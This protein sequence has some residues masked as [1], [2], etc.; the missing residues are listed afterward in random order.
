MDEGLHSL[1]CEKCGAAITPPEKGSVIA[2]AHCGHPHMWVPP[3]TMG[4]SP[5]H[6][7]AA[8]RPA[9]NRTAKIIVALFAV[10]GILIA[11]GGATAMI[12]MRGRAPNDAFEA[13]LTPDVPLV[14]GDM[15]TFRQGSF[16]CSNVPVLG[17]EADGRVIILAC[18]GVSR[19]MSVAR[20]LL[21]LPRFPKQNGIVNPETGDIVLALH[22][23][24]YVRGEILS[25]EPGDALRLRLLG[26]A[27]SA[28][29]VP[30]EPIVV[31]QSAVYLVQRPSTVYSRL[32]IP[33][34]AGP[35]AP[36][37]Q[38]E[39]HTQVATS[40]AV[41][42]EAATGSDDV[43]VQ[44]MQ[45]DVAVDAP[46]RVA[47]RSLFVRVLRPFEDVSPGD[48]LLEPS[49]SGAR[50]VVVVSDSDTR[51][52]CVRDEGALDGTPA[53]RKLPKSGIVVL[54]SSAR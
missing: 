30:A 51:D 52:V 36:G 2:C 31:A 53:C 39:D 4:T 1:E 27:P 18:Q 33:L 38:V 6:A 9:S 32:L 11:V 12:W 48:V 24:H 34:P 20:V 29:D 23:G 50:R 35:L 16:S 10:L 5:A 25:P 41:V 8:P 45:G 43:L 3:R 54:R 7:V 21:R 14:A 22:E 44:H 47:R 46:R 26:V 13:V 15:V 17:N 37:D 28:I 40:L 49:A 42:V 19:P